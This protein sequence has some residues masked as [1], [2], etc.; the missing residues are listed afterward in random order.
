M[1]LSDDQNAQFIADVIEF[2]KDIIQS[3]CKD[4]WLV[5]GADIISIFLNAEMLD[6]IILSIHHISVL[7]K[8]FLFLKLANTAEPK[9]GKIYPL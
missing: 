7:V 5:G 9:A 8:V 3:P 2:V 1:S 6:E 4:I